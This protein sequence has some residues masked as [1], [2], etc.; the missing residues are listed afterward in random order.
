MAF[1]VEVVFDDTDDFELEEEVAL[2]GM[3]VEYRVDEMS[4]KSF[5]TIPA[6]SL[7]A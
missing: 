4:S 7:S 5:S 1:E 6:L 2:G 3:A